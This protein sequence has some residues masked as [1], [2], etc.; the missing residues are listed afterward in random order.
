[1]EWIYWPVSQVSN[2]WH[3]ALLEAQAQGA[4]TALNEHS[5]SY[6][7]PTIIALD[8]IVLGTLWYYFL[9]KSIH[10]LLRK[11]FFSEKVQEPAQSNSTHQP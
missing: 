3:T 9:V 6:L 5:Q 4:E 8:C 7:L 10:F 11:I 1:M 2:I